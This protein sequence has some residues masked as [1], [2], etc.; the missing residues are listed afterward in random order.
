[1]AVLSRAIC[2]SLWALFWSR[3]GRRPRAC[4]PFPPLSA[5]VIDQT[6]T[7][8]AI[9]LKGLE[10]KLMAFEQKKGTQI[11]IL[12][13]PTT[14]PEDI[15][16]YA[17]RVGNAWKIGRKEWATACW[18]WWPRTTAR[19]ASRSPRRSKARFP[20]SRPGRSSTTPS[21]PTFARQDFAGGPARG[22]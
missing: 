13:V 21:R 19:F 14:Q 11:A 9:Q 22:R 20:T 6:G 12:M 1:M 17:N 5:L 15:A 10:D 7:L 8:D 4:F 2:R 16:S 3:L 18:W